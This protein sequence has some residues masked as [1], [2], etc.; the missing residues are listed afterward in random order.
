MRTVLNL[1]DE[2]SRK[3]IEYMLEKKFNDQKEFYIAKSLAAIRCIVDVQCM[4]L[5][6]RMENYWKNNPEKHKIEEMDF[7]VPYQTEI[8]EQLTNYQ[9]QLVYQHA[10]ELGIDSE[11]VNQIERYIKQIIENQTKEKEKP[12]EERLKEIYNSLMGFKQN[13]YQ[14]IELICEGLELI[15]REGKYIYENPE[16]VPIGEYISDKVKD[17]MENPKTDVFAR[18][19]IWKTLAEMKQ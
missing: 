16:M 17:Y 2:I 13:E 10:N 4:T 19:K 11:R 9:K 15:I 6:D 7:A 3:N 8:L 12:G 18:R 5:L 1:E 14:R